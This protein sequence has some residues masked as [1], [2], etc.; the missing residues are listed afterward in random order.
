MCLGA[1]SAAAD[2]GVAVPAALS[3]VGYDNTFL[4][5]LGMVQLTTVDGA[6]FEVGVQAGRTLNALL[7][8]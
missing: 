7:A 1:Y 2:L 5:D 4:A 3:L 6:G 8:G